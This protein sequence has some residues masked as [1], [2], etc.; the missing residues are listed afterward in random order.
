MDWNP[1]DLIEPANYLPETEPQANTDGN[2]MTLKILNF[3]T[4]DLFN[5]KVWRP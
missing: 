4:P 1:E 3:I 2:L 5:V